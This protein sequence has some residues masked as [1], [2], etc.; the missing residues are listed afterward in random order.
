MSEYFWIPRCAICGRFVSYDA[1]YSVPFGSSSDMEP[2]DPEYYCPRCIEREKDF[3]RKQGRPPSS[4]I[5]SQWEADLA[6]EL[7]YERGY[8]EW[9]KKEEREE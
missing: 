4:Y 5:P 1:D 3:Y 2:P 7:G 9:V 8:Y 6:A